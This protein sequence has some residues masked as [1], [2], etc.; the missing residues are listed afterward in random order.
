MKPRPKG[1]FR[2]YTTLP[3]VMDMLKEKRLSIV[4][5]DAWEDVNDRFNMD[6]YKLHTE[7]H[8]LGAY[9]LNRSRRQDFHQWKIFFDGPSGVCII[10]DETK[11][12]EFVKNLHKSSYLIGN[13]KYVAY[14]NGKREQDLALTT[15]CG[16]AETDKLPFIKRA[17]FSAERE[18]R[19]VHFSKEKKDVH[20][21]GFDTSIISDIILSPFL[22]DGLISS[23]K[24]I[25]KMID[26]CPTRVTKARLNNSKTWQQSLRRYAEGIPEV[27][28]A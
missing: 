15:K 22:P 19:I 3:I 9:C 25:L 11:F 27:A 16:R 2:R 28:N 17:G 8:F 7:T 26:G 14:K 18:F 4:G 23:V 21:I 12:D 13:M 6:L 1:I 24:S 10:F 20:H 5:Y